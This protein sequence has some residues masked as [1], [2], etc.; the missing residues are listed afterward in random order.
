[1]PKWPVCLEKGLFQ[2]NHSH[3]PLYNP[4]GY[5]ALRGKS[6]EAY[7][8]NNAFYCTFVVLLLDC[9]KYASLCNLFK[10]VNILRNYAAVSRN[11]FKRINKMILLFVKK[12][13]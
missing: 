1:M 3:G 12:I 8:W 10:L 13:M 11:V 4:V 9:F 6:Y 7:L 5:A 2:K